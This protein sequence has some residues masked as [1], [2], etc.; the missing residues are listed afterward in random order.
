MSGPARILTL[1]TTCVKMIRDPDPIRYVLGRPVESAPGKK[2]NYNSGI[3]MVLGQII[4]KVSGLRTDKFAERFL[5]E[6]LGIN[7]TY[8][9][10]YPDDIVETGGGL[11]LRPRDMAKLGRLLLEQGPLERQANR[12]R[13][14]GGGIHQESAWHDRD[15]RRPL[16]RMATDINGGELPSNRA[17]ASVESFSA[18]GRG[19]QFIFVFPAERMVA[20]F[21]GWNDNHLLFQPTDMVQEYVVPAAL[22]IAPA[23]PAEP[24]EVQARI[25]AILEERQAANHIPGLAFVAVKDDKVL[26]FESIGLRDVDAKLPVTPDT[27][28]PIGSCT[29]SFTSIAAGDQPGSGRALAR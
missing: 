12:Q 14:L 26:C 6:P 9:I 27:V 22:P 2:F 23:P 18:R 11:Y 10:K 13:G 29:K 28:F 16:A 5:F 1:E 25:R 4:R 20:V 21:T 17:I 8:W 24:K 19:G 7:D 3:S 15:F